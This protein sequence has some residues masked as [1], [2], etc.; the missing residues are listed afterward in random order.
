M[1]S[2]MTDSCIHDPRI[3]GKVSLTTLKLFNAK[4]WGHVYKSPSLRSTFALGLIILF[5]Y[6]SIR[7]RLLF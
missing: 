7:D 2:A 1:W 4:N 6:F 5:R 3:Q